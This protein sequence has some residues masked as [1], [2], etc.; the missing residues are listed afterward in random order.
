[1]DHQNGGSIQ[2]PFLIYEESMMQANGCGS[3]KGDLAQDCRIH[4]WL[5]LLQ[6]I[7]FDCLEDDDGICRFSLCRWQMMDPDSRLQAVTD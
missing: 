4:S 6:C 7:V 5:F 1:M 2:M 3:T